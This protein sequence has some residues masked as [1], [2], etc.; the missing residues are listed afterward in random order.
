MA[1]K[2][3]FN[4]KLGDK[5]KLESNEDGTVIGRAH[6]IDSNPQYKLRYTAG[7]GRLTEVWW[8]ESAISGAY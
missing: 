6:Y 2:K 8:D 7:D 1:V 4:F 5:V 3:T